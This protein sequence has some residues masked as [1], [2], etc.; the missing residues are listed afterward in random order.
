MK[1]L[2]NE[3]QV[4]E[5]LGVSLAAVRRWRYENRGPRF[6]KLGAAV[7]Y[8]SEDLDSWLASCPVGGERN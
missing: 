3:K 4:A 5:I 7:R 2:L 8:S 6:H 1:T